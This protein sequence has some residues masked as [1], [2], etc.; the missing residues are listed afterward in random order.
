MADWALDDV[1]SKLKMSQ[2]VAMGAIAQIRVLGGTIGLAICTVVLNEHVRHGLIL[3]L[4]SQQVTNILQSVSSISDLDAT[5]EK[6]VRHVFAEGY[7]QQMR[8]MTYFSA[9]I[10]VVSLLA[11]ERRPR[12]IE[13]KTAEPLQT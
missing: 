7:K 3:V 12:R 9:L 6:A 10:L 2:A 5:T 13:P 1:R 4:S 11:W 8:I